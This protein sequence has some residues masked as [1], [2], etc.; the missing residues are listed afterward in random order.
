MATMAPPPS[1][2]ARVDERGLVSAQ[3]LCSRGSAVSY[4]RRWPSRA[5]GKRPPFRAAKKKTQCALSASPSRHELENGDFLLRLS[6]SV[7]KG[8]RDLGCGSNELFIT[9]QVPFGHRIAI[10]PNHQIAP[11]HTAGF[12]R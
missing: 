1:C 9:A 4:R 12:R 5:L 11:L 7:Q 10:D 6:R 2:C 8:E 3:F